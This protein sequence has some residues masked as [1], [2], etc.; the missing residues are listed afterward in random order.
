MKLFHRLPLL[1]ATLAATCGCAAAGTPPTLQIMS[2]NI[3]YDSPKW[4]DAHAWQLRQPGA[5][6]LLNRH[7]PDLAG[8]QEVRGRQLSD[9]QGMLPD[10]D[11]IG[12]LPGPDGNPDFPWIMNPVFFRRDRLR[13]LDTGF[14]WLTG[15]DED[16][17]PQT[18]WPDEGLRLARPAHA[19]WTR[20]LDLATGQTF[21]HVNLHFPPVSAAARRKAAA[22]LVAAHRRLPS[23]VPLIVTGDFNA[24][25]E[26]TLAD[27]A[28]VGLADSR[29]HGAITPSGPPGTKVDRQTGEV[30]PRA[31]DHILVGAGIRVEAFATLDDKFAGRHPSDHLPVV[32]RL[33]LPE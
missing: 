24:P 30:Q 28:E 26:T 29:R 14:W 27:L 21:H 1:A 9:L 4:G 23:G 8:F 20:F 13:V 7:R 16:G 3:L 2:W 32:A 12:N 5:A 31:I 6:A 19:V 18:S 15:T 10:C 11:F 25:A 33:A 22:G 17:V